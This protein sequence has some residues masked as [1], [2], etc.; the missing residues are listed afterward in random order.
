MSDDSQKKTGG[1]AFA[2]VRHVVQVVVLLLFLVPVLVAGWS[3]F[4]G[5]VGG[6]NAVGTPAQLPF[7]GT[8]SSS[9]LFGITLLD[10]FAALQ[11]IAAA[12]AFS[13]DWVLGLL[14]LLIV[15]GLIRGRV[16]CGW[17]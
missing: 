8:L 4:G 14:P 7:Y 16:F 2:I 6:D 1:K 15:Y 13:P 5:T 11:T 12:K 17:V 3:L 9:T 10:P